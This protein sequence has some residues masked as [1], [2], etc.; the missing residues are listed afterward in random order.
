VS[1]SI[2]LSTIDQERFGIR[3]ARATS[4]TA[5]DLPTV[6]DF[7]HSNQVVF[8]VARC[9]VNDLDAAQAME[10]AGFRLMDTLIYYVRDL[11]TALPA[12]DIP[13]RSVRPD[14]ANLIGRLA[15]DAFRSYGGHY[16]ADPRLDRGKCDEVYTWWA[17]RSCVSREVADEV[18]AAE[19]DGGVAGFLTLRLNSPQE[20]EGPLFGV[21]PY[22]QGRGVGR[23]LMIGGLEWC[24]AKG[25]GRM[26]ISTQ[27]T[28][29]SSQKVWSRLGFEPSHGCYT[30]HRWF[31]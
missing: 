26:V 30:F 15:G 4:V 31:D 1:L 24:R 16:H 17:Y 6:I 23:S 7:C 28:N 22:V 11:N 14:E 3:S 8:L 29:L 9:D 19:I 21:S 2:N 27:I 13:V 25:A 20:G 10:T 18:L 5:G 12:G